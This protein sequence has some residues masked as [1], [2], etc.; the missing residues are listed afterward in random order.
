MALLPPLLPSPS[1]TW[2]GA[3]SLWGEAALLG[4]HPS[5]PAEPGT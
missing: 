4:L 1:S 5:A 2:W 3:A